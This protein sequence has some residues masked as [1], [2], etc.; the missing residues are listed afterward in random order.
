MKIS[1]KI[2]MSSEEVDVFVTKFLKKYIE[3]KMGCKVTEIILDD[4][5]VIQLEEEEVTDE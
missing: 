3:G 4:G 2:T 5:A 1:K